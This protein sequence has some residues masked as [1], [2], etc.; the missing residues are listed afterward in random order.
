M[1]VVY[2]ANMY[3]QKHDSRFMI[4]K[5]GSI[6]EIFPPFL[7]CY[8]FPHRQQQHLN[9]PL[10]TMLCDLLQMALEHFFLFIYFFLFYFFFFI[11]SL[12]TVSMMYSWICQVIPIRGQISHEFF[13]SEVLCANFQVSRYCKFLG[14]RCWVDFRLSHFN[15][16]SKISR[17]GMSK[18]DR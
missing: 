13:Y 7:A 18:P 4:Y 17:R 6:G 11:R 14:V 1:S 2:I 15:R 3:K 10:R 5:Y 12:S 8:K 9:R 16:H